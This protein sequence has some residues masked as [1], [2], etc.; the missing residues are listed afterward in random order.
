MSQEE[1]ERIE[2][3][4]AELGICKFQGRKVT[5]SEE[6]LRV[7]LST[8]AES[9]YSVAMEIVAKKRR[10][11]GYTGLSDDELDRVVHYLSTIFWFM[12]KKQEEGSLQPA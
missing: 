9:R 12:E 5:L 7:A 8:R 11:T 3:I 4:L 6:I 2:K 1:A 10:E